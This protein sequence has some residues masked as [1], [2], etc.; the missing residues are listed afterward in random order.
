MPPH[1]VAGRRGGGNGVN[2]ISGT[3]S[4]YATSLI[5]QGPASVAGSAAPSIT[6]TQF[7]RLHPG[8]Q[9]NGTRP[10]GTTDG[11]YGYNGSRSGMTSSDAGSE[12]SSYKADDDAMTT[13]TQSQ[14]GVTEY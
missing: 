1:L 14:A 8:G 10:A 6:S 5:S 12:Y 4:S 2:G 3:Y 9:G 11:G 13:Y 7:G